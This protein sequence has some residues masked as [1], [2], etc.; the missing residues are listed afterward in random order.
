MDFSSFFCRVGGGGHFGDDTVY[1][2]LAEPKIGQRH[3]ATPGNLANYK[4]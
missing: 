4:G 1:T 3:S 2:I